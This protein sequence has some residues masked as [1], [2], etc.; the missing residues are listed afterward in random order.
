MTS[1]PKGQGATKRAEEDDIE[2]GEVTSSNRHF[3][4]NLCT[5]CKVNKSEVTRAVQ[6]SRVRETALPTGVL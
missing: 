6:V 3:L 4:P 2:E 1:E 5:V